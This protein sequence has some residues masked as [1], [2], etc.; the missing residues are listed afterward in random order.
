MSSSDS[1]PQTHGI[2]GEATPAPRWSLSSEAASTISD[3]SYSPQQR[4]SPATLAG[5]R[6]ERV[7]VGLPARRVAVRGAGEAAGERARSRSH[8]RPRVAAEPDREGHAPAAAEPGEPGP[9]RLD[10]VARLARDVGVVEVLVGAQ[11]LPRVA[12]RAGVAAGLGRER[13]PGGHQA[14]DR[15]VAGASSAAVVIAAVVVVAVVSRALGR[16]ARR[17]PAGARSATRSARRRARCCHPDR[18]STSSSGASAG[19]W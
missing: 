6:G 16:P 11:V 13:R 1:V 5:G 17:A 12:R 4:P 9:R 2:V 18:R 3:W 7:E 15:V 8:R 10:D 19:C 14:R